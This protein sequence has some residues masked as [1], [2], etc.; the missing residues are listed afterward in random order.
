MVEKLNEG[1]RETATKENNSAGYGLSYGEHQLNMMINQDSVTV[2]YYNHY[3]QTA[4]N[5]FMVRKGEELQSVI[6]KNSGFTYLFQKRSC[7]NLFVFGRSDTSNN[8]VLKVSEIKPRSFSI[9]TAHSRVYATHTMG[10]G[11]GGGDSLK[12][13]NFASISYLTILMKPLVV[14]YGYTTR[15]INFDFD[16]AELLLESKKELDR[17]FRWLSVYMRVNPGVTLSIDTHCDSRGSDEYNEK[18][19]QRRSES[20]VNY[21]VMKG[22]KRE[23][24]LAKGYGKR[25]LLIKSA[26]TDAEHRENRRAVFVISKIDEK[27]QS[28]ITVLDG[29]EIMKSVLK[30]RKEGREF[31][32]EKQ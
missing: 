9:D 18:L 16:S 26:V 2:Q 21:L 28:E 32:G 10:S 8:A 5:K 24:L 20:C 14:D 30:I 12:K 22:L 11:G 19:S 1:N 6:Q 29:I 7:E 25:N 31:L 3:T 4:S 27:A 17:L 15:N 23:R 13:M